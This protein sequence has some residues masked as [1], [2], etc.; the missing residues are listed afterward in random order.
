M[1]LKM[2][3]QSVSLANSAGKKLVCS[4]YYVQATTIDPH[5]E[6]IIQL[7]SH[8]TAEGG[9][10]IEPNFRVVDSLNSIAAR[11]YVDDC[12]VIRVAN[13]TSDP[14]TAIDHD[15]ETEMINDYQPHYEQHEADISEQMVSSSGRDFFPD[16]DY[17]NEDISE[18]LE[19]SSSENTFQSPTNNDQSDQINLLINQMC[20][21]AECRERLSD[22]QLYATTIPNK[23]K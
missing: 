21:K 5:S 23:S 15:F 1:K 11:C 8:T 3:Q 4:C 12:L 10:L 18:G 2:C 14:N 17:T 6:S 20:Q 22:Y 16:S 7:Y 19:L 9:G 13:V